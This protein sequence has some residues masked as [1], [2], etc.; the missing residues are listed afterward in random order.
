MPT[1]A[2]GL[3]AIDRLMDWPGMEMCLEFERLLALD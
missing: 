2:R 1:S 3:A